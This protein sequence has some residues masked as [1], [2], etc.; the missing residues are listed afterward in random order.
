M[1][2]TSKGQSPIT[3]LKSAIDFTKIQS[4]VNTLPKRGLEEL[5]KEWLTYINT[6]NK[7][8]T[9]QNLNSGNDISLQL[10]NSTEEGRQFI[11]SFLQFPEDPRITKF[12]WE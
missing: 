11:S 1:I 6:I 4:L 3:E 12:D 8:I 9:L 10:L 7:Y 2:Q 5:T